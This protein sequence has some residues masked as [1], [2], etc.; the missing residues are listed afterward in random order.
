MRN[1]SSL[2]LI[3]IRSLTQCS[4]SDAQFWSDL[5]TLEVTSDECIS[6]VRSLLN[7]P[8]KV[9]VARSFQGSGARTFVNFLDQVSEFQATMVLYL[10]NLKR[11]TQV[12]ARSRLDG[13]PRQRCLRLLSKICK[14]QRI[15]P[16]SYILQSEFIHVGSVQDRGGFSEVSDGEYQGFTVAIK[17]LNTNRGDFDR[18][19]KVR[20]RPQTSAS[21]L[22]NL[23]QPAFL[24]RDSRVEIF[25]PPQH[26][27]SPRGFY[28]N[29]P[30][31]FPYPL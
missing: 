13:K 9:A 16:A 29:K 15:I 28:I 30:S 23:W 17:D 20:S 10:G 24:S 11:Q 27:A 26:L 22:F 8:S 18:V 1:R 2:P 4:P 6:K 12:L 5:Y 21:P 7:C 14:A 25:I 3:P 19:F 31:L